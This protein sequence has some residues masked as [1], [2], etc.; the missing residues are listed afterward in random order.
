MSRQ[1]THESGK[2]F[3]STHWLPLPP[4]NILGIRFCQ[5]PR[6][7]QGHS[8]AKR[9]KLTKNP[10]DPIGN[11]TH[12]LPDC[13][14]MPQPTAPCT[15]FCDTRPRN[16]AE[17]YIFSYCTTWCHIPEDYILHKTTYPSHSW[18]LGHEILRA[19]PN[20]SWLWNTVCK[21]NS[22]KIHYC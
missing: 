16:L 14:T 9:I 20:K 1:T 17:R 4:G 15:P 19:L 18:K 5:M 6:W 10:S 8:A 3:S 2:V 11:W 21:Q 7:P 12:N 13:S 22:L